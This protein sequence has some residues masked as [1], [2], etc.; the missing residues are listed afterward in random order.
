[1]RPV[2]ERS[3]PWVIARPFSADTMQSLSGWR[4]A[5]R[6]IQSRR[7]CWPTSRSCILLPGETRGVIVA[8]YAAVSQPAQWPQRVHSHIK[9]GEAY[10]QAAA[11]DM[12]LNPHIPTEQLEL[13][14]AA[15]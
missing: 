14:S 5:A 13:R 4:C 2:A 7:H 1:M 12:V 3:S 11:P 15:V 10:V 8:A 6:S 9:S